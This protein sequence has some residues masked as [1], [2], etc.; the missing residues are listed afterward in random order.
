MVSRQNPGTTALGGWG[1][2]LGSALCRVPLSQAPRGGQ[3]VVSSSRA[4]GP[5]VGGQGPGGALAPILESFWF[6]QPG[7]QVARNQSLQLWALGV[8]TRQDPEHKHAEAPQ[9]GGGAGTCDSQ[10]CLHGR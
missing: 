1:G 3:R 5:Q 2:L 6:D 4:T 9:S 7:P 10:G 8:L